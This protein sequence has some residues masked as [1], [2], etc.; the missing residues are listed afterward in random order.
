MAIYQVTVIG[1]IWSAMH[2][3][4]I[5]FSKDSAV[6]NETQLLAQEIQAGWATLIKAP[7]TTDL[8]L[9]GCIVQKVVTPLEAAFTLNWAPMS[10]GLAS[11]AAPNQICV[12]FKLVTLF[13]GRSKLGRIYVSGCQ[14]GATVNGRFNAQSITNYTTACTNLKARYLAAGASFTGYQ[15]GV[16][17]R[18]QYGL[19]GNANAAFTPVADMAVV[20]VPATQ[21]RRRLGVGI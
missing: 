5:Y 8:K 21:R 19:N 14:A 13:A 1:N 16:F 12:L 10:G 20:D 9:T 4:V 17:S 18:K 11:T 2:Q 3:N 6:P 7:F 15:L